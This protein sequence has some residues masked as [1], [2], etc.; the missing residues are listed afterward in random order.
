MYNIHVTS[1]LHEF[2]HQIHCKM[3]G[4]GY[5]RDFA[6]L[7]FDEH[8]ESILAMI[9]VASIY[10]NQLLSLKHIVLKY[11]EFFHKIFGG[12]LAFGDNFSV[13]VGDGVRWGGTHA[14]DKVR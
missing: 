1:H 8:P 3:R 7:K 6:G 5:L 4:K 12:G 2:K 11:T 13:P 14:G 10:K 9:F